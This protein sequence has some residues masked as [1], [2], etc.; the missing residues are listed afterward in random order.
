MLD[1]LAGH[2]HYCFL[3]DYLGY[4]QIAITLE[5]QEKTTFNAPATFQRC[6]MSMFSDLIEKFMEMF[7]DDFSVYGSS[8]RIAWR[9]WQFYF[10]GARI[11]T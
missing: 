5:D 6:M 4:N 11:R 8:L 3:D 1:K 9:I 7:M 2:P 10:R